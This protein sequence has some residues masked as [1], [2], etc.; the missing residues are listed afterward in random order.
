MQL[1]TLTL[2]GIQPHLR[3]EGAGRYG[4]RCPVR[5]KFVALTPEEW[6][7]QHVI[8]YLTAHRGYPQSLLAVERGF[9]YQEMPWRADIVAYDRQARAVLL[10]E[11]KAPEVAIRQATFEQAGRYNLV[12]GA[13]HVAVSNGLE[14]YCFRVDFENGKTEFLSDIPHFRELTLE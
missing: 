2:P 5:Q 4:I 14:H 6:V 8:G 12:V 13:T 1:P 3:D 9:R 7:R 11:C 10:V